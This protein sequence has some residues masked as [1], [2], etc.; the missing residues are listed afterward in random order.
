MHVLCLSFCIA[1][2]LE[3]YSK[4]TSNNWNRST[5]V[6]NAEFLDLSGTVLSSTKTV[7]VARSSVDD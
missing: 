7:G 4:P 5:W 2:K 1:V 6:A 3:Y